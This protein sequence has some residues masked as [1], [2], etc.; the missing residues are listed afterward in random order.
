MPRSSFSLLRLSAVPVVSCLTAK[1]IDSAMSLGQETML[2]LYKL[3]MF[4]SLNGSAGN[5]S[6]LGKRSLPRP[7]HS[8]WWRVEGN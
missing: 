2:V 1:E 6:D 3:G 4:L 7:P 5:G 8:Q